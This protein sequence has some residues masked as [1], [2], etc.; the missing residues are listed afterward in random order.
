MSVS[1][2]N[3]ASNQCVM[4][5]ADGGICRIT[6][7]IKLSAAVHACT[8]MHVVEYSHGTHIVA[9]TCKQWT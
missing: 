4:Q 3:K 8:C 5:F 1:Y 6:N 7:I 9:D 2:P